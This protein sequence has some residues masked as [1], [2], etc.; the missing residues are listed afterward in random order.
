MSFTGSSTYTSPSGVEWEMRRAIPAQ[1]VGVVAGVAVLM[2]G[3]VTSGGGRCAT[4][5][6]S[7]RSSTMLSG[8]QGAV[9]APWSAP[10]GYK[11]AERCSS[12]GARAWNAHCAFN[13]IALT[14][15]WGAPPRSSTY[16][17][18]GAGGWLGA[19]PCLSAPLDS[20]H[21]D[22]DATRRVF[23]VDRPGDQQ[24]VAHSDRTEVTVPVT[25]DLTGAV[26]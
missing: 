10:T 23:D 11:A 20:S 8:A 2:V 25:E 22:L 13:A 5:K 14:P 21:L 7:S 1:A 17:S 16:G 6:R 26:G 9:S 15:G 3:A 24:P 19:A 12:T 18:P 4:S